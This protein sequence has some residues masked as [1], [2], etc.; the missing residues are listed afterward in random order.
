MNELLFGYVLGFGTFS[1]IITFILLWK[2]NSSDKDKEK[3]KH[4]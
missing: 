2:I 4:E 1:F 3:S